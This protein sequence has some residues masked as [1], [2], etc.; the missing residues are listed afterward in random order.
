MRLISQEAEKLGSLESGDSSAVI[1]VQPEMINSG[2][3]SDLQTWMSEHLMAFEVLRMRSS[4]ALCGEG[5]IV[6]QMRSF[7]FSRLEN[8]VYVYRRIK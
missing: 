1:I 5:I 2:E 6:E 7:T 8:S 3:C 4:R